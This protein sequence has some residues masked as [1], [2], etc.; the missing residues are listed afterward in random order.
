M[1][2]AGLAGSNTLSKPFYRQIQDDLR[3]RI[4]TGEWPPGTRLPSTR[5]LVAFYQTK[6][7]SK[8]LAIETV[9]RAVSLLIET[10]ELRGQQGLGVFVPD[11]PEDAD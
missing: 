9:R 10:G 8:T 7:R 11:G 4:A 2:S 3:A 6:L 1:G 5:E